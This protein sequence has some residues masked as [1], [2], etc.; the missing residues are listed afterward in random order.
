MYIVAPFQEERQNH[1]TLCNQQSWGKMSAHCVSH[2][3]RGIERA[4]SLAS[5][6]LLLHVA[7]CGFGIVG[8]WREVGLVP[9]DFRDCQ[10]WIG[11]FF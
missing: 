8:G 2:L 1:P 4:Q 3:G 10:N 5:N 11:G 6:I 7:V 9:V